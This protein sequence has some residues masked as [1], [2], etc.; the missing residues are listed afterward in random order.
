MKYGNIN[1]E[2][3]DLD[4]CV[5]G[6]CKICGKIGTSHPLFAYFNPVWEEKICWNCYRDKKVKK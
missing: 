5:F 3:I 1:W 4:K 6:G 2:N